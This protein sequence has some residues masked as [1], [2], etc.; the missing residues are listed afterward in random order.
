[1]ISRDVLVVSGST[2]FLDEMAGLLDELSLS[3][4]FVHDAEN[5]T[6]EVDQGFCP[7][8]VILDGRLARTEAEKVVLHLR[9]HARHAD[10]PVVL[11]SSRPPDDAGC[12]QGYVDRAAVLVALQT[13]EG[14]P[15]SS[16][17]TPGP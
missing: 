6:S 16:G 10:V 13:V 7:D 14:T 17:P 1:M 11:I 12:S 9:S 4:I 15:A 5:A 3:G 8:I 2:A